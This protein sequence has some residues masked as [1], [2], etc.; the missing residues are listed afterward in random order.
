MQKQVYFKHGHIFFV[1]ASIYCFFYCKVPSDV[2]KNETY[3]IVSLLLGDSPS[4]P[5]ISF[6]HF[7]PSFIIVMTFSIQTGH[8][9]L[10]IFQSSS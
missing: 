2:W 9:P 6:Y 5:E 8:S 1:F 10:Q 7:P 4:D 3:Q